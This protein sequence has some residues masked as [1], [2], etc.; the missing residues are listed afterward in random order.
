[1]KS[2][3]YYFHE[4]SLYLA[5]ENKNIEIIK[6]L[7]E[8]NEIE[9]NAINIKIFNYYK[10]QNKIKKFIT[11]AIKIFNQISKTIFMILSF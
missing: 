6:L 10:I 9:I 3:H 7:L 1:M 11:F 5:V 8:N 4:T 2:R